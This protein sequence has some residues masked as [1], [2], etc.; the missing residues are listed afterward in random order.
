M[1]IVQTKSLICSIVIIFK[2]FEELLQSIVEQSKL[3]GFLLA[4]L[5][6]L[7]KSLSGII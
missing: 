4:F 7:F 3:E 5:I 2:A 6:Y 1:L